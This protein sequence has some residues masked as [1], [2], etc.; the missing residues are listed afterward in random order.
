MRN[1]A[2]RVKQLE[3]Q[4]GRRGRGLLVVDATDKTPAQVA[5]EVETLDAGPGEVV[6]VMDM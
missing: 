1:I 2:N 5:A 6:I 4:T 3:A